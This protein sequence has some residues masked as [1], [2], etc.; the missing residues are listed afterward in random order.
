MKEV[1][2]WSVFMSYKTDDKKV[3][4]RLFKSLERL[5]L[6]IFRDQESIP[7]GKKWKQVILNGVACTLL[8]L[9]IKHHNS[10]WVKRSKIRTIIK[11]Y[12]SSTIDG[13]L[14]D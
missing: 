12:D 4:G 11:F 13:N 7:A 10:L 14:N 2:R 3:A 9:L 5:G 6:N 1:D 8:V